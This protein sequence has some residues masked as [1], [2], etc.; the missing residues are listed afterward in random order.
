MMSINMPNSIWVGNR[1]HSTLNGFPPTSNNSFLIN[2]F[3]K[4]FPTNLYTFPPQ[5]TIYHYFDHRLGDVFAYFP[6]QFRQL[7]RIIWGNAKLF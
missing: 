7:R 4:L 1:I 2:T 6:R 5:V 3:S